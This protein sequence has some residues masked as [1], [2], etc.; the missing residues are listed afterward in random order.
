MSNPTIKRVV[1]V[2]IEKEIEIEFPAEFG[3]DEY[4]K[5]FRSGLWHVNSLDDVFQYAAE[6][7]AHHGRGHSFDGLGLLGEHDDQYPHPPDVK[8]KINSDETETEIIGD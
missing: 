4:L 8:F 3:G 2:T 1:R 6:M 5:N 7:A